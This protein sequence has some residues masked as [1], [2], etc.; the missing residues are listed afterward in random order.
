MFDSRCYNDF[1]ASIDDEIAKYGFSGLVNPNEDVKQYDNFLI[2]DSKIHY[3]GNYKTRSTNGKIDKV[4]IYGEDSDRLNGF[5]EKYSNEANS[6]ENYILNSNKLCDSNNPYRVY[7]EDNVDEVT[8]Q[9]VNNK[10]L[11]INFNLHNKWYE[12]I[13]QEELKYIDEVV[14]NYLTQM[15]PSSTILQIKYTSK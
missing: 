6:V 10:R 15:I 4:F 8:N 3:F 14:M 1:Y 11:L 12:K 7:N 5:Q 13:G 9:I 2:K